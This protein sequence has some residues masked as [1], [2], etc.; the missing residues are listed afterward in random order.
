MG[1]EKYIGLDIDETHFPDAGSF[2]IDV[3][4]IRASAEDMPLPDNSVDLA[5]SFNVFEHVST[6][7]NAL[8]EIIRA[9]R[10]GGVFYTKFGPPFNAAAGPHLTRFVDLPFVHH[11]FPERVV[12]EFTKRTDAY[13]TVNKRPLRYYRAHFFA[14]SGFR[15]ARYREQIDGRGFWLLRSMPEL[16]LSVPL[17]ELAV[18]SITAVLVKNN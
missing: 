18:C 14:E 6:P 11:L 17:D 5:I 4:L 15:L 13:Y 12:A 3:E 9:L 1:V 8:K 10:P 16:R 2:E 7:E